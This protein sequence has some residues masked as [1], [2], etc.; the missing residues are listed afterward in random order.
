MMNLG[1]DFFGC[2]LLEICLLPP[3]SRFDLFAQTE[4]VQPLFLQLFVSALYSFTPLSGMLV[5]R[6]LGLFVFFHR[7]LRPYLFL[8]NL[9]SSLFF[10]SDQ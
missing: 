4:D 6:T 8:V 1:M 5:T 7:F 10:L 9:F 3:I 2:I